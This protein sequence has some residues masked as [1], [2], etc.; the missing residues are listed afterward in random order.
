MNGRVPFGVADY[1]WDEASS[2]Q[3]LLDQLMETFR[4]W[5]YGDVIPPMFEF[6]STL[7]AQYDD[8]L[9]S[10]MYRFLD[11]D[12]STLSLRPEFTTPV[13]R[14]V[15]ARLH[16]WPMPQRFCYGGS[17]FRYLEPQAGRQREFWQV[18]GELFGAPDPAADAEI[19][20]LT[21]T[22]L[23]VAGLSDFRQIVGH[24]RYYRSL[25]EAL[26]L[27]PQQ[28]QQLQWALER[29]SEPLLDD[30][31]R[32]T[33]LRTGQRQAV[34]TLPQ[35]VGENV[36]GILSLAER[37][38]QNRGMHEALKNMRGMVDALG[39]Y[40]IQDSVIIDLTEIRN[41]G[42]YTGVSFEAV[43]PGLG[44]AVAS[45]GRYDDLVGRFGPPQPAVGVALGVD[46]LLVARQRQNGQDAE[47]RRH[48]RQ[49]ALALTQGNPEALAQVQRL[50]QAGLHIQVDVN[51]WAT[52]AAFAYAANANLSD[53]LLWKDGFLHHRRDERGDF[54]LLGPLEEG[55]LADRTDRCREELAPCIQR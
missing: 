30:F 49:L 32:D 12:G 3:G 11:R 10:G 5:G 22:S 21:A 4:G 48:R 6:D 14:L 1:F 51:G 8:R 17:V 38:I 40:D 29:K 16:D 46:R 2:R 25:L 47:R 42:Y 43:T 37:H 35:L 55:R 18:G 13:A 45:G 28:T 23:R 44:T 54:V 7:S 36:D 15:G 52:D 34:E 53:V 41:L 24:I 50:R 19:L 39:G 33:P 31:L 27:D 20:A 26:G 9:R